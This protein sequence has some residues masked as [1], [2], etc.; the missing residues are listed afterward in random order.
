MDSVIRG[1]AIYFFLLLIFKV[2][3]KR[4]LHDTTTFDFV[5]LLIISETTQ[6][7]LLADDFSLVNGF[8]LITTLVFTDIVLSLVKQKFKTTDKVLDGTPTI[9][10][11]NGKLLKDRMEK[12]RVDEGDI[13]ESA[14]KLRGLESMQQVKYAILENDGS[15]SII[16]RTEQALGQ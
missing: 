15:I 10:V 6:Q 13:M 5:L 14:R 7:A 9:L 2:S 3:G 1:L 8:I 12:V 11:D 16:P 4:S